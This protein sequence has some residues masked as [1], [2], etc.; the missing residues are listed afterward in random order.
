MR[1]IQFTKIDF[2]KTKQQILWI[3][4]VIPVIVLFMLW[5]GSEGPVPL[6][7]FCY[8]LFMA[9]VFSTTPFGSCQ[10]QERGFLVL[11]PATTRDRISGRFLYGLSFMLVSALAGGVGMYLGEMMSGV[12]IE[13][14]ILVPFCMVAFAVCMVLLALE[15]V[16]LYLFGEQQSPNIL[17]LIRMIPGF[18][19]FFGSM[20]MIGSVREKPEVFLAL[21]EYIDGHLMMIG[22][23]SLAA[24][25][26]LFAAAAMLCTAV[27]KKRDFE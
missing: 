23:C 24:A 9:L 16:V 7:I 10:W 11:L 20:S 12:M 19:F 22:W 25:F 15:Y 8:T 27:T 1:A 26:V 13:A 21:M 14:E 4:L 3:L 5:Q 17:S 6:F 2:I 18:A